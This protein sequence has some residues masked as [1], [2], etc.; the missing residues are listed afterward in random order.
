[1]LEV[2]FI[3]ISCNGF[4]TEK[5]ESGVSVSHMKGYHG[6]FKYLRTDKLIIKQKD[7]ILISNFILNNWNLIDKI[8]RLMLCINLAGQ[9]C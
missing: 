8:S 9:I 1:M 5:G 7:Q 2:N 3:E 6:D 4:S